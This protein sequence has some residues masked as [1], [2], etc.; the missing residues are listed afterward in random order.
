MNSEALE[1]TKIPLSVNWRSNTIFKFLACTH[2]LQLLIVCILN[3]YTS[4]SSCTT[5]GNQYICTPH[6]ALVV[7]LAT[8]TYLGADLEQIT[9]DV[10]CVKNMT[11]SLIVRQINNTLALD[12]KNLLLSSDNTPGHTS[13]SWCL[14]KGQ[15]RFFQLGKEMSITTNLFCFVDATRW[16]QLS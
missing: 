16:C 7:H 3:M 10:T 12:L 2:P 6:S 13:C 5:C 1:G 4:L 14:E 15:H 11:I 9:I 8:V